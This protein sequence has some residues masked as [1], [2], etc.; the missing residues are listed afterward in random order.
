MEHAERLTLL[1]TTQ[2]SAQEQIV[3]SACG[4]RFRAGVGVRAV[5]HA[6]R[7]SA[8]QLVPSAC[9]RVSASERVCACERVSS[10]DGSR[11]EQTG[12]E[13]TGGEQTGEPSRRGPSRRAGEQASERERASVEECVSAGHR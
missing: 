13:Q 12:A 7:A 4:H 2:H 11:G 9:G 10:G 6:S 8:R 1:Y 3:R 5:A